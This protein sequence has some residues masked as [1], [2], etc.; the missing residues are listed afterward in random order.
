MG[1]GTFSPF[2]GGERIE[3]KMN[4]RAGPRRDFLG[5]RIC[6]MQPPIK[7]LVGYRTCTGVCVSVC[8]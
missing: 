6:M 4:A 7:K 2:N 3:M 1:H 8:T 5:R